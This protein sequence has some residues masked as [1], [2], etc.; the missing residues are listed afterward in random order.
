MFNSEVPVKFK[1]PTGESAVL[2]FPSDQEL[3]DRMRAMRTIQKNLGRGKSQVI[4][5]NSEEVDAALF[6]KICLSTESTDLDDADKSAFVSRLLRVDVLDVKRSG[7]NQITV[8]M[9]TIFG[10]DPEK[11][12]R[13]TVTIP[14]Q[15]DAIDY[16]RKSRSGISGARF[17]TVT[18]TLEPGIELYDKIRIGEEGFAP[19]SRVPGYLKGQVIATVLLTIREEEDDQDPEVVEV[20]VAG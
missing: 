19:G 10:H 8:E 6:D 9:G 11:L 16:A 1:I 14:R 7:G 4:S 18:F 13:M 15:K 5:V 20:P 17:D 3:C 2:R 12:V